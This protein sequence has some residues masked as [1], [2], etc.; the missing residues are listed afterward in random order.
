MKADSPVV[1]TSTPLQDQPAEVL[2]DLD[3]DTPDIQS[4]D[5]SLETQLRLA[6]QMPIAMGV[7]LVAA[8]CISPN[9]AATALAVSVAYFGNFI[10]DRGVRHRIRHGLPIVRWTS[11]VRIVLNVVAFGAVVYGLGP[12]PGWFVLMPVLMVIG[13]TQ[14]AG[15][16]GGATLALAITG[17]LAHWTAGGSSQSLLTYASAATSIYLVA[18]ALASLF[19]KH[20]QWAQRATT[21]LHAANLALRE[22][23]EKLEV[24]LVEA[25]QASA[26]K[27]AFLANMS[28]ELRTPLNGISSSIY[29]LSEGDLDE[30]ERELTGIAQDSVDVLVRLVTDILDFARLEAGRLRIV[31][32]AFDPAEELRRVAAPFERLCT[33]KQLK[34]TVELEEPFPATILGDATRLGQIVRNLLSNAIKFT[35]AGRVALRACALPTQRLRVEVSD[36]GIG[37]DPDVQERIFQPFEQADGSTTRLFGGTGLGLAICLQLV[38]LMGGTI[39]VESRSGEGSTFWLELPLEL[40]ETPPPA[41]PE[42]QRRVRTRSEPGPRLRVLLAED[43]ATNQVIGVR[44][45]QRSDCDVVCASNGIEAVELAELDDFDL[46]LMDGQMPQM[47]G[48]AATQEIRRRE[49]AQGRPATPIVALTASTR[50]EDRLAC[51][52]AGMSGFLS[53]PIVPED[54]ETVLAMCRAKSSS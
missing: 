54:L 49:H 30:T 51:E 25:Q 16:A 24:L 27:A 23:Q 43:N 14:N 12:G 3:P 44:L 39:G 33:H 19:R 22:R 48:L 36:T 2:D 34:L 6:D 32:E 9:H 38:E 28:H 20:W 10:I 15:A 37:L 50:P 1:A 13:Y 18:P 11:R 42:A 26:A 21:K 45:L 17:G 31:R 47:D 41:R 35:Q 8:I 46:I 29:L 5:F 40:S 7:V 4:Y 53:K 52:L